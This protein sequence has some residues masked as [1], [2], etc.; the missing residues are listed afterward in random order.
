MLTRHQRQTKATVLKGLVLVWLFVIAQSL[1]HA[2]LLQPAAE[3]LV[4]GAAERVGLHGQHGEM[5]G[6]PDPDAAQ[7]LCLKTCDEAE[8]AAWNV[9][10]PWSPDLG[11]ALLS[12]FK[13]WVP[14]QKVLK[15]SQ[16]EGGGPPGTP[17]PSIRFLKLNR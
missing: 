9:Q 17:P 10:P 5:P 11:L 13:P 4:S 2:C 6:P 16:L 3:H 14:A 1:A 7:V 8:S 12:A 15:L